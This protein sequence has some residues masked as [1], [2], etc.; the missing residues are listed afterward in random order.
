MVYKSS[1]GRGFNSSILNSY[2]L[3]VV[4]CVSFSITLF[5][6]SV[7]DAKSLKFLRF[8]TISFC[9][10]IFIAVGKPFQI[11][12][13]LLIYV[14]EIKLTR[15]KNK[16]LL[17]ENK[18]LAKKLDEKNFLLLENHRL[19]NLL[20]IKDVDYV[21]KITSRILIDAYKDAGSLIYIDVGKRDGL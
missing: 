2:V 19:R 18:R 6:L 15:E 8:T 5:V 9:K 16:E 14:N 17:E 12:N 4:I 7:I 20:K 1:F 13:G 10:P 21:K 3:S 11:F